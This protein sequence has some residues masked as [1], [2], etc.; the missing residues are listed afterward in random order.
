MLLLSHMHVHRCVG[1]GSAEIGAFQ[2]LA[3]LLGIGGAGIQ[4]SLGESALQ[5]AE[6]VGLCSAFDAFGDDVQPR[7]RARVRMPSRR[8]SAVGSVSMLLVKLRSI[9]RL[10]RWTVCRCRSEE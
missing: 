9:F 6:C 5:T 8:C 3:D 4:V 2:E 10:C 7:W 1:V